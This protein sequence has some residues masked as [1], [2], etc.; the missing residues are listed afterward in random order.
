MQEQDWAVTFHQ[1]YDQATVRY[2]AGQRQPADCFSDP[3]KTFLAGLGCS[4]Q[5]LFDFVEDACRGGAPAFE[6]VLLV[7]ATRRE[8]FHTVQGGRPSGTIIRLESLPAKSAEAGGFPWL[9]RL[10]AKAHAKL[11][12]EMPPELMYGC[13][14]DLAF[15]RQVRID[16]ADFL[17]FAWWAGDDEQKIIE[18]VRRSAPAR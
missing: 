11:R 17:R 8:F 7:T 9:P 5:E 6:T 2:R 13:S 18:Y 1:I 3:G 16:L 10:I 12:G 14:G 4:P 15:L